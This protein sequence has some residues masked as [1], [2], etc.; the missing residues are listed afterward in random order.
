MRLGFAPITWNNE[1]LGAELAAAVP[2][3]TVLDEI[4]AAGYAATELGDGF[5]RDPATLRAA[6]DERGLTL[7]SAWCGLGL[8]ETPAHEDL[9]H[10]R[11]LCRLVS[12]VGGSFVN[13]AHHGTPARRAAAGRAAAPGVPQLTAGEWDQLAERVCQSAE[14]AREHGLQALFHAHVGTWVETGE[15][16]EALLERVPAPLLKLCWDVGHAVYGGIDPI[17]VVRQLPERIAYLH[18]KDVDGA[19][20]EALRLDEEGFETGIRRRVFTELGHGVLEVRGLLQAL[21]EIGYDGWLM[22]EQDSSWLAPIDSARTSRAYL[23][24]LGL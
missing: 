1:D 19:V 14:V 12:E 13:L 5:P 3:T 16:L 24:Q 6:L 15:E 22:V 18:L 11:G 2:Y 10:T 9:Q 20:L 7:T 21:R 17:D 4:A 8:L 23:R